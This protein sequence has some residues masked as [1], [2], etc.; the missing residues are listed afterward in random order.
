MVKKGMPVIGGLL[1]AGFIGTQAAGAGSFTDV[2]QNFWAAS[3]ISY[4]TSEG[5]ISGYPSDQTFRPSGEITRGETAAMLTR[6]LDL[7]SSIKTASFSDV[8]SDHPFHHDIAA[9]ESND[10]M[11][12]NEHGNFHPDDAL[13][14]AEMAEVLRNAFELNASS[15]AEV[16]TDVARDHWAADAVHS[17]VEEQVTTGYPD[18]TYRPNSETTRAEFAVFTARA[19]TD[20]FTAERDAA[21]E[22][23]DV[24]TIGG[25]ALGDTEAEVK[26][27]LGEPE[28]VAASQYN[29]DWEIYHDDY[30]S[31]VQIGTEDGE[32]VA[33]YTP[34]RNWSAPKT[35]DL[36]P[37]STSSSVERE[38][39][40]PRETIE[41]DGVQHMQ[42][43]SYRDVHRLDDAFYT[44][45]YDRHQY[46]RVT[47]L[48][49]CNADVEKAFTNSYA[50]ASDSWRTSLEAQSRHL[51]NATRAEEG[52]APV[53]ANSEV[54]DVAR[55]HSEDMVQQQFF[56]HYSPDGADLSDRFHAA[57]L[58]FISIGENIA[59]GQTDAIRAH[60]GWMNSNEGHREAILNSRYHELGVGVA[61]T[62]NNEPYYTQNY[63]TP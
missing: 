32:V 40:T 38:L 54:A 23:T 35:Y 12:G 6:A 30:E 37:M 9:V 7:T 51:V 15:E 3:E 58:S 11:Q 33:M 29:F 60:E 57:E 8:E 14:R 42:R 41:K 48:F 36:H 27:T 24:W 50:A 43:G 22:R 10:I 49:I 52:I 26:K 19:V 56:S 62:E 44:F 46:E 13:T 2:D 53:S 17:L 1:L 61:F 55:A 20:Q 16:F 34:Q 18:G 4:M 21:G 28:A 39:G 63:Y 47:S 59:R 5:V 31:Y 45:F 25:V